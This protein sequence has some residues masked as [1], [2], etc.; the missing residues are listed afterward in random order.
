MGRHGHSIRNDKQ[1]EALRERGY[2]KEKSARIANA[3]ASKSGGPA[4][5]RASKK[6][7]H[8]G[9]YED[10]K[11]TELYR[12]AKEIGLDVKSSMRKSELVDVLRNH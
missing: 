1:Y 10:W 11:K 4:K 8:A 7:G 2:S 3:N 5:N 6:G 9:K 12:K